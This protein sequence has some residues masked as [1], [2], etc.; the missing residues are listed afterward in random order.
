MTWND[1]LNPGQFLWSHSLRL[2]MSGPWFTVG[3]CRVDHLLYPANHRVP[4]GSS[5]RLQNL[6]INNVN[7]TYT[8]KKK[9][10]PT[11]PHVYIKLCICL[12]SAWT[13]HGGDKQ[14]KMFFIE[15]GR[16]R[17][18]TCWSSGSLL[19][20]AVTPEPEQIP[21]FFCQVPQFWSVFMSFFSFT[22]C[23]TT[24]SGN[25]KTI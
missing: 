24:I 6:A 25:V 22:H 4:L 15:E 23:R 13:T 19:F 14:E 21:L 18:G 2:L 3:I 11:P 17:G 7:M 16:E 9:N 1:G 12:Y 10:K 20:T 5:A 8:Q